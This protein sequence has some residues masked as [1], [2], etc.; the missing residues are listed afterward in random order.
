M[1]HFKSTSSKKDKKLQIISPKKVL[2]EMETYYDEFEEEDKYPKTKFPSKETLK[3][4]Q[5]VFYFL[6]KNQKN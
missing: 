2:V 4:I 6:I 3:K 1:E 5:A